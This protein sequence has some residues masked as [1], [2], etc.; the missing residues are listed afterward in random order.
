MKWAKWYEKADRRVNKTNI[1]EVSVS[2]VF[3]GSDHGIDDNNPIIFETMIFGGEHA[4]YQE[5][6]CT[7]EEAE[8]MHE[9]AVKLITT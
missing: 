9:K 2:T 8:I 5:R 3:L 7:W 6:C 1:G 4:E